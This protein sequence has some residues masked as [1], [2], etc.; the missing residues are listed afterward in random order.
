MREQFTMRQAGAGSSMR[1][2]AAHAENEVMPGD[3]RV[4]SYVFSDESVARDG[5]TIRTSGWELDAFRANPVFLWCHQTSEPPIG[6]VVTVGA[7]GSRLVGSVEFADADTYPFADTIFRLMKGGYLNAVSVQWA[8]LEWKWSSDKDRPGG[9]DFSRQ[10]LLEVSAVPV[11]ALP[12]A[13]ATARGQGIDTRPLV[14]WA[15]RVLDSG[16]SIVVPRDELERLRR[17]AMEPKSSKR[18]AEDWKCGASKTLPLDEESSWDGPAA[19]K[20]IFEAC[21]FDGDSPDAKKARKAFLAYDASAPEKRGSYKLPFA[22]VV[23]GRLTAVAS[24]IRAAASRL[25]QADI[26]DGVQ[27]AAREVIDAYEAKMKKEDSRAA[28]KVGLRDLGAVSFLASLLQDL[29]FLEEWV[30]WETEQEGDGSE[31]PAQLAA[32]LK[33]LGQ[34]LIAMTAEEVAELIGKEGGERAA[35]ARALR[36]IARLDTDEL[37]SLLLVAEAELAGRGKRAGHVSERV[38]NEAL[39]R[40]GKTLSAANEAALEDIHD[41]M[42]ECR[43]MMRAFIDSAKGADGDEKRAAAKEHSALRARKA[44]AARARFKMIA[45]E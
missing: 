35:R 4:I 29:G 32:A 36:T 14:E 42:D 40:A 37:S 38:T 13:L 25:P 7:K 18:A 20:S 28:P 17:D 10:E 45:A 5:H 39:A 9:I 11:P 16:D 15:E 33:Q 44:R 2:L 1:L 27:T 30:E 23:D 43:C 3:N 31:V 34:V 21:G 41:R 12:T 24:G 8:P 6:R 26:P 19:E 22:K